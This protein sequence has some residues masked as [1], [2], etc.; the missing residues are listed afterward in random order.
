MWSILPP[1]PPSQALDNV[2][3]LDVTSALVI[4]FDQSVSLNSTGTQHIKIFDDMGTAG[5]TVTN[6]TSSES[7]QDTF[8]QRR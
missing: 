8:R 6:T 3:N 2:S 1:W 7:K 5:W 4:A